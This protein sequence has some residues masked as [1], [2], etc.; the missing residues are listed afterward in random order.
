MTQK[1]QI[2][3]KSIY[4]I[5][6]DRIASDAIFGKVFFSLKKRKDGF[7]ACK[8]Y[9]NKKEVNNVKVPLRINARIIDSNFKLF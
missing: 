5:N 7:I 3:T 4:P 1:I 9:S 2:I 8:F 6:Y